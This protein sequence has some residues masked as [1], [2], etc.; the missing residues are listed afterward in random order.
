M[1]RRIDWPVEQMR[2][3]YEQDHLT[4]QEIAD[5]LGCDWRLVQ[6]VAK[7]H[8][9]CL[10]SR[11]AS[12]SRNGLWNDGQMMSNG[13]RW[14][15]RP[16]HPSAN[17]RG[18]VAEHRL[19]MEECLGRRLAAGEVVHH[20]NGNKL[21]N[22]IENLKLYQNNIAHMHDHLSGVPALH[23][24]EGW[25]RISLKA[26]KYDWRLLRYWFQDLGWP[27]GRIA[28][29]VGCSPGAVRYQLVRRGLCKPVPS[30]AAAQQNS[31]HC[32]DG[33]DTEVQHPCGMVRS[34]WLRH[35]SHS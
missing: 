31:C 20:L 28:K 19:V 34:P 5:R 10:R 16:G 3:W 8:G 14:L 17:R 2:T 12:G 4:L 18:Y 27:P 29:E 24:E 22:R 23:T 26:T 1:G 6:K 25:Q 11:G 7:K 15:L 30:G 21:D 32:S 9:F 35:A 13:Y 33:S